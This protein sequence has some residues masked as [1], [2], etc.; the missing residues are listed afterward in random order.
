MTAAARERVR[1]VR[2]ERVRA[3]VAEAHVPNR[4]EGEMAPTPVWPPVVT[5]PRF[6]RAG[7][8]ERL[9]EG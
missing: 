9:Y 4:R 5:T 1:Q 6:D 3:L 7:Q 2:S 8:A